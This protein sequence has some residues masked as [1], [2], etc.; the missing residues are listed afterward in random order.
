MWIGAIRLVVRT[1][2]KSF[3]GT[4]SLVQA[5]VLRDDEPLVTL[6]LDHSNADDLERGATDTFVYTSL[7]TRADKTPGN[8]PGVS[9]SLPPWPPG[10]ME[11][12]DGLAGHLKLRLRIKGSDLWIKD[13][14]ALSIKQFRVV[15]I[16]AWQLDAN[17][18]AIGAW[19]Q[20]VTMSTDM[21][22]GSSEWLMA[23]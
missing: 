8:P 4:D 22:E 3:A 7:P 5:V 18:S 13:A 12:S 23:V 14:V 6:N 21:F 15:P 16:D 19:N 17:W 1:E 9:T 2:D 20:D 10:G 11:F